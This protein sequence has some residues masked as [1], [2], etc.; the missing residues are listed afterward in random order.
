MATDRPLWL[1]DVDGVLN[2]N[3]PGWGAAPRYRMAY[4]R[5]EGWRIRWAPKLMARIRQLATDVEIQ[6]ATTWIGATAQLETMFELPHFAS[7]Y[8]AP[9]PRY[10]GFGPSHASLKLD[11]AARALT[12]GRRLI[13]TDDDAIPPP[14]L[15][16]EDL[17]AR[18]LFIAPKPNRGLQPAHLDAIEEF[19]RLSVPAGTLAAPL[20]AAG[21]TP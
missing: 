11:A 14:W 1:L 4:I 7:A 13:W 3:R 2:A 16:R 21:G 19:A 18:A 12:E 10:A 20:P 17:G 9:A 15:A 6:W 5:G 8:S